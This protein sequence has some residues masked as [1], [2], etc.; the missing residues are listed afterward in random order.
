MKKKAIHTAFRIIWHQEEKTLTLEGEPVLTYRLS[1]PELEGA[2]RSG[3]RVS[4]YYAGLAAAWRS[5]WGR[6][7]YWRA[8]LDLVRCRADG[9]PFHPW[10]ATLSGRETTRESGSLLG[11]R[12]ECSETWGDG[13]TLQEVWGDVWDLDTGAPCSLS[14]AAGGRRGWRRRLA[15]QA[16]ENGNAR[17]EAGDCFLDPD[18]TKKFRTLLPRLSFCLFPD[19]LELLLP[20]CAAAPAAEGVV[21]LQVPHFAEN[22]SEATVMPPV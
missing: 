17:R 19:R 5:R 20:Q 2:G 4:R 11:L 1:W 14:R 12:L 10:T 21:A 18:W 8:C 15:E 6:T 16:I 7:L 22:E 13:R 3:A 9:R